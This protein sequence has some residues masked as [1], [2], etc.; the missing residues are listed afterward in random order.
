[1][2]NTTTVYSSTSAKRRTEGGVFLTEGR[3]TLVPRT[4]AEIPDSM[5]G[6]LH[7]KRSTPRDTRGARWQTEKTDKAALAC[8]ACDREA[9]LQACQDSCL[10]Q[11]RKDNAEISD[12]ARQHPWRT[13]LHFRPATRNK[14]AVLCMR[15]ANLLGA[16]AGGLASPLR[17][18]LQPVLVVAAQD[19][20]GGG[21][22]WAGRAIVV[23][24]LL[25]LFF[26]RPY[27]LRGLVPGLLYCRFCGLDRSLP[28][29][30][31]RVENCDGGGGRSARE[32]AAWE[33]RG[34]SSATT[35]EGEI[36]RSEGNGRSAHQRVA[37]TQQSSKR[38]DT[39][40]TWACSAAALALCRWASASC[41][42]PKIQ[43][44]FS[45]PVS[46]RIFWR[47]EI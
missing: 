4:P 19:L 2:K 31:G 16:V 38:G 14:A 18:R 7:R 34:Q 43:G 5:R 30:D 29:V 8:A 13:H 12:N 1:M 20:L 44:P 26:F 32:G 6:N 33:K 3:S 39:H 25:L 47:V 23:V 40:G 28:R 35:R 27:N 46:L 11:H 41:S 17:R 15:F 24:L 21:E 36:R 22:G 10:L 37:Y 42:L 45:G 9:R